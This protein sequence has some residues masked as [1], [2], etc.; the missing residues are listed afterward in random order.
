MFGEALEESPPWAQTRGGSLSQRHFVSCSCWRRR[1]RKWK[2]MGGRMA[3]MAR[4]RIMS[5]REGTLTL[6]AAF[7]DL[8]LCCILILLLCL[9]FRSTQLRAVATHSLVDVSIYLLL[10]NHHQNYFIN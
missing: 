3:K 5:F 4:E 7:R 8:E 2:K 6:N 10:A 9:L 1:R